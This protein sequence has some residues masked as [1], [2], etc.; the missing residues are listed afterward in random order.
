MFDKFMEVGREWGFPAALLLGL[1]VAIF[2]IYRQ[3]QA[4]EAKLELARQEAA[5]E[6]EK[7]KQEAAAMVEK[8]RLAHE[9][10]RQDEN[11]AREAM[12]EE[13]MG[14]RLDVTQELIQTTMFN[15]LEKS[16]S[17]IT[18]IGTV[19]EK[20]EQVINQVSRT[21]ESLVESNKLVVQHCTGA[22]T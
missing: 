4:H 19:A 5:A 1:L 22:K 21:H 18:R 13:R 2:V 10:K 6:A 9:Q 12:R 7:A 15:Q 8:M 11:A 17:A 3:R 14:K 16:N 20:M